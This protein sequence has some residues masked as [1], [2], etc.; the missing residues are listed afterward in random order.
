MLRVGVIRSVA[1]TSAHIASSR[2]QHGLPG[3]LNAAVAGG[4]RSR[5]CQI[6]VCPGAMDVPGNVVAVAPAGLAA[7]DGAAIGGREQCGW[8]TAWPNSSAGPDG[9][10]RRENVR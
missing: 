8:M 1:V 7:G 6:A 3:R 10:G 2:R 9:A 4:S 5:F